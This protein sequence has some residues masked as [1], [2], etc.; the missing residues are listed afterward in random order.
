MV[1]DNLFGKMIWSGNSW[2]GNSQSK[3][4]PIATN[5]KEIPNNSILIFS[6]LESS[7]KN[8]T[9]AISSYS[10]SRPYCDLLLQVTGIIYPLRLKIENNNIYVENSSVGA[11]GYHIIRVMAF[12]PGIV[13][14]A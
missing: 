8:N 3:E 5:L 2:F 6:F 4:I 14:Y 1:V 11:G 10:S 12:S 9:V 7:G 13:K